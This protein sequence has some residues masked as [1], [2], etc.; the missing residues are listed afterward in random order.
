MLASKCCCLT[1]SRVRLSLALTTLFLDVT[2]VMIPCFLA[3]SSTC[4]RCCFSKSWRFLILARAFATPSSGLKGTVSFDGK[5]SCPILTK[6]VGE[7]VLY[8]VDD[9]LLG[10][11]GGSVILLGFFVVG[12]YEVRPEIFVAVFFDGVSRFVFVDPARLSIIDLSVG[13]RSKL[14]LDLRADI[15]TAGILFGRKI[16][17]CS[18]V[19]GYLTSID[20]GRYTESSLGAV[21]R[22]PLTSSLRD[23]ILSVL[24][25]A[26]MTTTFLIA[27]ANS[28]GLSISRGRSSVYIFSITAFV[29]STDSFDCCTLIESRVLRSLELSI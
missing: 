10:S 13:F 2:L 1:L 4:R 19:A 3:L 15:S 23:G 22:D 29:S 9:S 12:E 18:E 28:M 24:S 11:F 21:S 20:E 26:A 25:H 6:R 16:S 7:F 14:S 27:V 17:S 5:E 8:R